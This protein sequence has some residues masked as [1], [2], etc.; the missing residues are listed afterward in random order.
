[1]TTSAAPIAEGSAHV[2]QVPIKPLFPLNLSAP[3]LS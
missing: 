2:R 1:V 3:P